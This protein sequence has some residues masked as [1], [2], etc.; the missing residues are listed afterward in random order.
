LSLS[1]QAGVRLKTSK[2]FSCYLLKGRGDI[3]MKKFLLLVIFLTTSLTSLLNAKEKF[4]VDLVS[5]NT[6][7]KMAN[8][9]ELAA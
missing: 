1:A 4:H 3:K 7:E 2:L 5:T 9:G 6:F 8:Y